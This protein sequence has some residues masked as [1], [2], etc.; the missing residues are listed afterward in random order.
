MITETVEANRRELS[1]VSRGLG[2]CESTICNDVASVRAWVKGTV[3]MHE[4]AI[5]RA[6]DKIAMVVTDIVESQRAQRVEEKAAE[7][8]GAVSGGH[9]VQGT[10]ASA[11]EGDRTGN[12]LGKPVSPAEVPSV[13]AWREPAMVA[14]AVLLVRSVE[15]PISPG[16]L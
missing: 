9:G 8:V 6:T 13:Q 7:E 1:V 2:L 14:T 4:D 5:L 10:E 15:H 3:R 12:A 11:V 16:C